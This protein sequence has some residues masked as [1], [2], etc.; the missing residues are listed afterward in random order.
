MPLYN[1]LG[2]PCCARGVEYPGAGGQTAPTLECQSVR[3]ATNVIQPSKRIS[4]LSSLAFKQ[5]EPE[6]SLRGW[7]TT[8]AVQPPRC[9]YRFCRCNW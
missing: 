3:P 7:A 9:V 6:S 5:V 1:C 4:H 2:K 8:V